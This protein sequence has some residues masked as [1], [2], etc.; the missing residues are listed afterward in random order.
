M[1]ENLL[2]RLGV[3]RLCDCHIRR[4]FAKRSA[5]FVRKLLVLVAD[6]A[7][8]VRPAIIPFDPR[9]AIDHRPLAV[10]R[11]QGFMCVAIT[12]Q[13]HKER[14]ISYSR[15]D[16]HLPTKWFMPSPMDRALAKSMRATSDRR[17]V[18]TFFPEL[19]IMFPALKSMREPL[20]MVKLF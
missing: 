19:T 14:L 7:D 11:S 5:W 13:S 1:A 18:S 17:I 9:F 2:D 3:Q 4:I 6:L 15:P 8:H 16:S 12:V 10:A 20:G